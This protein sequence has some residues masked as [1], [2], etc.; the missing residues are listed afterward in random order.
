MKQAVLQ[1]YYVDR[2]GKRHRDPQGKFYY[3]MGK[4]VYLADMT[5][6]K[7]WRNYGGYSISR[8]I[9][10]AFSKVK[11]R[12]TIIYRDRVKGMLYITNMTKFKKKGILV[13]YGGHSQ[14]VLPINSFEAKNVVLK[15]EPKGLPV[16]TVSKWL[17]A[18]KDDAGKPPRGT[19]YEIVDGVARL[20]I[21]AEQQSFV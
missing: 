8:Q 21:V 19:E 5:P 4:P 1:I 11:V 6:N 10:D 2:Y 20:K 16:L 13:A 3:N 12:P 17:T 18:E 14:Y 9:L 15:G 7:W